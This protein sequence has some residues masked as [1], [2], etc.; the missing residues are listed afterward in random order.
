VENLVNEIYDVLVKR[1]GVGEVFLPKFRKRTENITWKQFITKSMEVQTSID[2]AKYCG[3]CND[4]AFG[5]SMRE[6]YPEVMKDKSGKTWLTY[7]LIIV[8]KRKCF[9]CNSVLDHSNF[10][11]SKSRSG[12]LE[13]QCKSCRKEYKESSKERIQEWSKEYFQLNKSDFYARNAHY[14][15]SKLQ[16]T[17]SWID[18]EK[19]KQIYKTCPEGYH[20]DHIVPL[21]GELVCGLHCEFNLQHLPAKDNLS[22][23]NRFKVC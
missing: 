6:R 1:F 17:P 20:V 7:F 21:Q 4:S 18:Q 3:Y 23:N 5:R 2:L 22:K 11:I 9:T 15:A 16:A 12:G 8:E 10:S 19:I 14:R 13:Y